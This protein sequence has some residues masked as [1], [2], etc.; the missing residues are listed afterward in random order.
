MSTITT[1]KGGAWLLE[2]AAAAD[3]FTPERM[4]E[5]HRLIAST[6]ARFAE[7]EVLP[8]LDRLEAKD[9]AAARALV[10]RC[11][12]LGLLGVN[13]PEAYGG[14]DLDEVSSLVV[15][16]QLAR[17]ASFGATY[18]AQANLTILPILLFGTVD[19]KQRYLP[20]LATGELVGA[21]ARSEAGSGSD[22]LGARARAT[23]RDNDTF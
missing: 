2:S 13:V 21:Y 15:S 16:Q 9:W 5:E 22:A 18:G 3:V 7:D 6:A 17:S 14:V 10:K 19:Q 12:E 23:R 20:R 1:T 8:A 11:G 4:T